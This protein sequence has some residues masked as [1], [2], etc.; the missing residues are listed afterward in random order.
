[1]PLFACLS[2]AYS[3]KSW[4][5]IFGIVARSAAAHTPAVLDIVDH[6]RLV[7]DASIVLGACAHSSSFL[8]PAVATLAAFTSMP[9]FACLS[10][11]YSAKSWA[12]IFGIVARSAAAHTPTVLDIVHHDRL[13]DNASI[14]LG[15]FA[16][17]SRF[18]DV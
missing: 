18:L 8:D 17:L 13:V 10:A 4:A 5:T 16:H 9:L 1:M 6:D 7:D 3:A 11:A 15:A 14:V 2:A 12:T